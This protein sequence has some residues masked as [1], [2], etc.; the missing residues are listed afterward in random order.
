MTSRPENF[1]DFTEVEGATHAGRNDVNLS[2]RADTVE[3]IAVVEDSTIIIALQ[4][5]TY[6]QHLM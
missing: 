4:D 5:A 1:V 6:V 2:K 3:K